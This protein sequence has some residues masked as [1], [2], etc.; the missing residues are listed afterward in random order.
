MASIEHLRAELSQTKVQLHQAV[1]A[2]NRQIAAFDMALKA[3][4]ELISQLRDSETLSAESAEQLQTTLRNARGSISS[5]G[6][7]LHWKLH[8]PPTID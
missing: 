8:M 2:S 3:I 7:Y 5:T 4:E 1:T 6:N